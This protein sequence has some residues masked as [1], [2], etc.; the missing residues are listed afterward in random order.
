MELSTT[1]KNIVVSGMRPTGSLHLG[2]YHGVIENWVKLQ[3]DTRLQERYIFV[4]DWHALTTA[5]DNTVELKNNILDNVTD[6]LAYG[7]DPKR[8]TIFIQSH[9]PEHA[10]LHVLMS[11]IAPLGW[12]ERVPTFKEQQQELSTK[13]LATLGFLGYPVLQTADIA[14]YR[15]NLVPVGQDQVAHVELSRE[16]VR[17]FNHITKSNALCEP[18]PLLTSVPK[19]LGTDGRK[20]SKSYN[21]CLYLKDTPEERLQKLK[22]MKTDPARVRRHDAGDPEKCPL[23]DLHRIYSPVAT[24]EEI[25][26]ACKTASIGCSDC[27]KIVAEQMNQV[28][29][30]K[31]QRRIELENDPEFVKNVLR[32]GCQKARETAGRNLNIIKQSWNLSYDV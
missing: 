7:L 25:T 15:A 30:P 16:I 31:R 2:H 21:N 24:H 27:K 1:T 17:R 14:L 28:L 4:A 29:E 9:V 20:M 3:D 8:C 23:F 10:E 22:G 11:M 18:Q 6:W 13:D 32:E 12:L 19:L 26:Q 5:Y